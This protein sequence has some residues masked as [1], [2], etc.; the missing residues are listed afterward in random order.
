MR[1]QKSSN[2]EAE[3]TA[4]TRIGSGDL[5]GG[6]YTL[7]K[8]FKFLAYLV[9]LLIN[10]AA[11]ESGQCHDLRDSRS[12]SQTV[13]RCKVARNTVESCLQS[14][15][16]L[17]EMHHPIRRIRIGYDGAKLA[18]RISEGSNPA[19]PCIFG[20]ELSG[21]PLG[22][23]TKPIT[24]ETADRPTNDRNDHR[25]Y[26][27]LLLCVQILGFLVSAAT[28]YIFGCTQPPNEKS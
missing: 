26:L 14:R 13:G 24:D 5:L 12:D 23:Q 4:P 21:N 1:D 17:L 6:S 15:H 9:F 11:A 18:D 16:G 22:T 27:Y 25:N 2:R 3:L 7:L 8:S 10:L 20:G 28:G 19:T